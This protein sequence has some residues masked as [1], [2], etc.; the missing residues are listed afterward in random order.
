MSSPGLAGRFFTSSDIWE[1]L[2]LL[3]EARIEMCIYKMG[4]KAAPRSWT[5]F[6]EAQRNRG[7]ESW[8]FSPSPTQVMISF[9]T[10][11]KAKR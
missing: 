9:L 1:G 7:R 2:L 3:L 8:G 11:F 4:T 5:V 6:T 10:Q